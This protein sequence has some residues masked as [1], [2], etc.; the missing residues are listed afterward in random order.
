[1]PITPG[2]IRQQIDR[3][4]S[5]LPKRIHCLHEKQA[6]LRSQIDGARPLQILA[7]SISSAAPSM[8]SALERFALAMRTSLSR[9][10]AGGR[11]LQNVGSFDSTFMREYKEDAEAF[12]KLAEERDLG[13]PR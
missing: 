8:G 4:A 12:I 9:G 5:D 1:M 6:E 13:M 11:A 3:V 2:R 10:R 7:A